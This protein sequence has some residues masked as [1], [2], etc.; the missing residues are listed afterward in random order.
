M[1]NIPSLPQLLEKDHEKALNLLLE[2]NAYLIKSIISNVEDESLKNII[3]KI[4][5]L[6]VKNHKLSEISEN[7]E[8]L[9]ENKFKLLINNISIIDCYE[10]SLTLVELFEIVDDKKKNIIKQKI[11]SLKTLPP[12]SGELVDYYLQNSNFLEK[13]KLFFEIANID[14][15]N[16]ILEIIISTKSKYALS[17]IFEIL[18]L[19]KDDNFKKKCITSLGNFKITDVLNELPLHIDNIPYTLQNELDEYFKKIALN[20][21]DEYINFIS[22]NLNNLNIITRI[23]AGLKKIVN[24]KFLP[25]LIDIV[26]ES[27]QSK[28]INIIINTIE[29]IATY[30]LNKEKLLPKLPELDIC[31]EQI[32]RLLKFPDFIIRKKIIELLLKFK[33]NG[34]FKILEY[35]PKASRYDKDYIDE[36]FKNSSSQILMPILENILKKSNPTVVNTIMNLINKSENAE[37]IHLILKI[38]SLENPLFHQNAIKTLKKLANPSQIRKYCKSKDKLLRYWACFALRFFP[39]IEN[40]KAL[41]ER[42]LDP[43][44]EIRIVS[45]ESLLFYTNIS[46]TFNLFEKCF[47]DPEEKVQ[48]ALI[49]TLLKTNNKKTEEILKRNISKIKNSIIRDKI[50]N[51]IINQKKHELINNYNNIEKEKREI[52]AKSIYKIDKNFI[53]DLREKLNDLEPEI[54]LKA[55]EILATITNSEDPAIP[56]LLIKAANDPDQKIRATIVNALGKSGNKSS[57]KVLLRLLN[58]PNNRV[59]ANVIESLEKYGNKQEVIVLLLPY[60]NDT[61]NRV[62]ANT[63]VAL[64]HLGYKNINNALNKLLNH[65]DDLYVAS[66]LYIL[67][68]IKLNIPYEFLR[69]YFKRKSKILIYNLLLTIK[70]LNLKN[71]FRNEIYDK[72]FTNDIRIKKLAMELLNDSL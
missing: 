63:I 46:E 71:Y 32:S 30:Y 2:N 56:P 60:L 8:S 59:R 52:I 51:Y 36:M 33:D 1:Q 34:I 27:E 40:L 35:Y 21:P 28:Q 7:I 45:I 72:S 31:L 6:I 55:A 57:Y 10:T 12:K 9:D 65:P 4:F 11:T 37:Y 16:R 26:L 70:E 42:L 54:R 61:N 44:A 38:L 23:D 62:I 25:L 66:G 69:D 68:N 5:F 24:I 3:F 39:T 41:K 17:T 67:R 64:W 50:F 29:N 15:K 58:D 14:I 13:C 19:V 53:N 43:S 47:D 49:N 22:K 48:E 18:T 20:N